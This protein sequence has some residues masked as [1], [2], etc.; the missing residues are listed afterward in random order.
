MVEDGG[1][2]VV[3]ELLLEPGRPVVAMHLQVFN[4]ALVK[5][6][7]VV[8]MAHG[9]PVFRLHKVGEDLCIHRVMSPGLFNVVVG[10]IGNI[11][12]DLTPDPA[13]MNAGVPDTGFIWVVAAEVISR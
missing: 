11:F 7:R 1:N 13:K 8:A 3:C 2:N 12:S 6:D 10:T 5:L 4:F 9:Y